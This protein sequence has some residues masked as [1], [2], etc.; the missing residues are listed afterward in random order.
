M[1]QRFWRHEFP[2][3]L[4]N[5][6]DLSKMKTFSPFKGRR[7]GFRLKGNALSLS[8][9][10][11]EH[12]E[13][14]MKRGDFESAWKI[15]DEIMH[16]RAGESCFHLPRHQQWV[17][18]GEPL[19]NRRVLVRC[20]HGLGDTIMFIRYAPLLQ[21]IAR[22]MTF[23]AQPELL[24]LLR[25][26]RGI[27]RLLPLHDGTPEIGYDVDVES[28]ELPHVF[29]HTQE[30]LPATVPYLHVDPVPLEKKGGK[31]IGLAWRSGD[32]NG[33]RSVPFP[34]L[35]PLGKIP[36]LVLHI[37]QRGSGLREFRDGFGV[38]SGSDDLYETARVIRG[39]D[40]L[41]SVDTMLVHLAGALGVPVWNLLQAE[42]D[43][44]WME[45]RED[46]PWYP[47]M[48]LFR[49]EKDGEWEPVIKKVEVELRKPVKTQV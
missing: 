6:E 14:F 11:G 15:S 19:E 29:R 18:K 42:A 48:R 46:S 37:V 13:Y 4:D 9:N 39:L 34:L 24:P 12:W 30:T 28:M 38:L 47:T 23:W 40:L 8:P 31:A 45:N 41:I 7:G 25:T 33:E 21:E 36:G 35:A 22:E 20:Y 43:W 26:A 17:W 32:W 10:P 5:K 44:R 3:P 16:A 27:D 1:F 49:Q 2:C